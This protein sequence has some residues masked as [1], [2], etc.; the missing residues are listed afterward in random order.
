MTKPEETIVLPQIRER[1][2]KRR[3][4]ADHELNNAMTSQLKARNMQAAQQ[5]QSALHAKYFNL[6][7]SRS[8]PMQAASNLHLPQ[9]YAD[10]M[11]MIPRDY[12]LPMTMVP[13]AMLANSAIGKPE[14]VPT[15]N[16][17]SGPLPW[18]ARHNIPDVMLAK[19]MR[20][21]EDFPSHG[22]DV[23]SDSGRSVSPETPEKLRHFPPTTPINELPL[24]NHH[25]TGAFPVNLPRHY[26]ESLNFLAAIQQQRLPPPSIPTPDPSSFSDTASHHSDEDALSCVSPASS[27]GHREDVIASAGP[28]CS[29]I[30]RSLPNASHVSHSGLTDNQFLNTGNDTENFSTKKKTFSVFTVQSLLGDSKA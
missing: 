22:S 23:E 21:S 12:N 28:M 7:Q 18:P 24:H 20:M 5:M 29:S 2:R 8:N 4:F 6:L 3:A 11:R 25:S 17:L 26:I 27:H 30:P 9:V 15:F 1:I 16:E 10:W 14:P 19:R 13:N